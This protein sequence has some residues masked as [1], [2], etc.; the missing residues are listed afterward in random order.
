MAGEPVIRDCGCTHEGWYDAGCSCC[1]R[2]PAEPERYTF[3]RGQ[4][5]EAVSRLEAYPAKL[6]SGRV[7]IMAESVA[8]A[9]IEALEAGQ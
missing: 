2:R 5:I 3:T 4:L 7:V 9:I 8:D 6:K 1:N